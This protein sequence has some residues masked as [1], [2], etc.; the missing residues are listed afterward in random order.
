[1]EPDGLHGLDCNKQIGRL[2]RHTE[3]NILIKR[4]Y[5]QLEIPSI[6]EPNHLIDSE[7]R[8]PDGVTAFAVKQGK[9]VTWDYT[10]KNTLSDTYLF[11]NVKKAGQAAIT[12]ERRKIGIYEERSKD[13]IFVLSPAIAAWPAFSAFW[14]R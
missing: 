1:M 13:Y 14:K 4:A 8:R 5:A 9:C 7:G 11:Q 2:P 6:L 10:C 3:G 12:G